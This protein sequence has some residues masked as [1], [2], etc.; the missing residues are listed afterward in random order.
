VAASI[1]E[2]FQDKENKRLLDDLVSVGVHPEP[3][4]PVEAR[5]GKLPFAGKTFVLTGTL[6]KRSRAEAETVIKERGGKVSGSVSKMTSYVL[7]GDEAGSKLEKAKK[8]GIPI[9]DE[10][11]FERLAEVG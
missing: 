8:L 2:Y 6:P 7:D 11:E 1:Y 5:G 4:V 9:I 3:V 10:A